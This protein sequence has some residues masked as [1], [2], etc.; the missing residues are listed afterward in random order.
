MQRIGLLLKVKPEKIEEY[1]ALHANVWPDLLAELKA[2]GIRNYSLWLMEDGTEFGYLEC[3]DWD[4][5]CAY[6][7]KSEVHDR[8]QVFMQNYLDPPTDASQGGQPVQLL[9]MSFLM[10]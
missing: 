4:A 5:S 3:D 6:L 1:K 10:E 9:K 7:T 2:A 8:W